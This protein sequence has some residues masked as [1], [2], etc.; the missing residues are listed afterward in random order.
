MKYMIKVMDSYLGMPT[1]AEVLKYEELEEAQ[2]EL[3]FMV[4]HLSEGESLEVS[5]EPDERD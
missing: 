4:K 1:V 2:E 5:I 3:I